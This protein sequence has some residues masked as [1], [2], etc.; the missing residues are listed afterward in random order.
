MPCCTS[1][2][3]VTVCNEFLIQ[4]T[5][6][7]TTEYTHSATSPG[8]V[9]WAAATTHTGVWYLRTLNESQRT[10][11]RRLGGNARCGSL[12]CAPSGCA[13]STRAALLPEMLTHLDQT[14]L[15]HDGDFSNYGVVES[16]A[17]SG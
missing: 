13:S 15:S 3:A 4:C 10:M 5:A 1:V 17:R 6:I 16:F 11:H 12:R 14:A 2:T 8:H 7:S 9:T